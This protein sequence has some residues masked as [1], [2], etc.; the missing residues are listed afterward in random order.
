VT[1]LGRID[2]LRIEALRAAVSARD[3]P[4]RPGREHVDGVLRD[5]GAYFAEWL[6][7]KPARVSRDPIA[8]KVSDQGTTPPNWAPITRENPRMEVINDGQNIL[9]PARTATDKKGFT[10]QDGVQ[11]TTD[12]DAAAE[13]VDRTDNADGSTQFSAKAPG[14]VTLTWTAGTDTLV[15]TLNI[16]TGDAVSFSD[17]EPVITDQ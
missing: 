12:D 17:I 15:D 13:F 9:Y 4:P 16:T 11:L 7:A 8:I 10:V 2:V 1:D 6:D 14:V 5:A 3:W